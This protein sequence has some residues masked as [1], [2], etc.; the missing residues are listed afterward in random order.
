MRRKTR[1]K[2]KKILQIVGIVIGIIIL[3][4]GIVF[5]IKLSQ[6]P[7]ISYDDTLTCNNLFSEITIDFNKRI[8]KRDNLETSLI[9]EFGISKEEE[10]FLFSNK[11][12]LENFLMDSAFDIEIED[13]ILKITDQ[14]QTKS[15]IVKANKIKEKIEGEKITEIAEGMY[16]LKFYSE[17]LTKAMFNYYQNQDYIDEIYYDE[18]LIDKPLNDISQ[19]MYGE[20]QVDLKNYHTIGTTTLGLDNY[21][22]IINDNGNP[23]E[24]V[25]S[26]IGYGINYQNEIFN[27]R[28]S[29]NY[30][31]FI[32]GNKE[33]KE[34]IPQ[35]SRIAEVIVDSTTPN[36]KIMPLV[37]VTD[38]GYTS[39]SSIL[40]ALNFAIKNSD[41][42][43][44]EMITPENDTI[45]TLLEEAFKENKPVCSVASETEN[46]YPATHGMTIAIS[47]LDRELKIADYS[48]KGEYIDFAAP[49]T[50]IEEIFNKD[51]TV[52]RWS[53]AE[54]S[55]AQIS[56]VISL[57]KT[58]NKNATI[59]DIYN[60]LRNFSIDLGEQGKDEL[61]GYGV[62]T[63]TNLKISDIDKH[64]PEFKDVTYENEN[65]EVVKQVKITAQDNIRIY[66]WAIT[67]SENGPQDTEWKVLEAI[68][69]NLDVTSEIT[70]NGTY[71]IW[72][73]DTAG[74]KASY[75]I[76]VD[77]VDNKPPQI[78][79]TINKDTLNSGYVTIN[80]TAEDS[81]SGLYDS[82]FSWDQR[83]W[84]A[85]NARRTVKENGRYKVYAEDNLGNIGELEIIVDCFPQSGRAEVGEGNIITKINVPADWNENTNNSVQ[86]TLNKEINI[87][88]WQITN[89]GYAPVEFIEVE[90]TQNNNSNSNRPNTQNQN[91]GIP[92]N[93]VLN[94]TYNSNITS[95]TDTTRTSMI[96]QITARNENTR[97]N[98][99][100]IT[101]AL[102]INTIYYLWIKDNNGN[103]RY[104]TFQIFKAEI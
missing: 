36:V 76:Q 11:V 67:K 94:T 61:F 13:N 59:L 73:Q 23:S 47:S 79:Y 6:K 78:A 35:G 15:I 57:I 48:G 74:N 91:V 97:E 9:D 26:T 7:K 95:Q 5:A 38:E 42:I 52:S 100:I 19:T 83:T 68:T 50:D 33:I 77:R 28:L 30:Y 71:Y 39:I 93:V 85:E 69:P 86:I 34:T 81:E 43:C 65:W 8:V 16:I 90:S 49:S 64:H 46:N 66:S 21:M 22:K 32:L 53:G 25:I 70:E 18:I 72:I 29:E 14:F 80:V 56:A 98:P 104:Q 31:N 12:E 41:V 45:D 17:K 54:Y 40:N 75:K 58:Y 84:S 51:S 62:P 63:F 87:V 2:V 88:G 1:T 24:V 99:I 89:N 37:T 10:E 3:I 4:I 101:K 20:T 27:G 44:Y 92:N 96:N 103:V 55:N 60:F 102:Q 82:P